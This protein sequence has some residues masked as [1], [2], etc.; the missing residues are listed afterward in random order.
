MGILIS[1]LFMM[2]SCIIQ[3]PKSSSWSNPLASSRWNKSS[4]KCDLLLSSA[5][6]QQSFLDFMNE[7][8]ITQNLERCHF[9]LCGSKL[10]ADLYQ[11]ELFITEVEL[12]YIAS[13]LYMCSFGH[14]D[15]PNA[16]TWRLKLSII[17]KWVWSN[18][19]NSD[20]QIQLLTCKITNI[21]MAVFNSDTTSIIRQV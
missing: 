1:W 13:N 4:H 17:L 11:I 5:W 10:K 9:P 14:K 18:C 3:A 8:M 2:L 15:T 19:S 7:V 12:V 20:Q 16:V 21:F 6:L